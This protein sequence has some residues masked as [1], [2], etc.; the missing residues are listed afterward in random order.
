MF[1]ILYK[2]VYIINFVYNGLVI[3]PQGLAMII[4]T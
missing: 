3:E 1:P 4:V 2:F